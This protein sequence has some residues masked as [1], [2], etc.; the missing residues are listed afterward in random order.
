MRITID[1]KAL[2]TGCEACA[3]VCGHSAISMQEDRE[4]FCYPIIDDLKCVDCGL[5]HRICPI[6]NKVEK[7]HEKQKAFGGWINDEKILN[8][9]TSGGAFSAIADCWCN[10]DSY[11]IFGAEAQGMSVYHTYI[12]NKNELSRFRQS[13]YKQSRINDC[14]KMALTFLRE[15]KKVLFAGTPCQI[16]ALKSFVKN[17]YKNKLLTI[18]VIC[19]GVPSPML[20][21]KLE[22]KFGPISQLDY[23]YK[24]NNKWDFQ[25]M[26]FQHRNA[27]GNIKSVK[28][29][30]WFNPFWS[31]WLQHLISRPSCYKCPYTTQNRVADIT[32]GDL[33]GVHIYCPDLYNN[34]K[35]TS[36]VITNTPL[37]ER[38]MSRLLST[39]FCGRELDLNKA[40]SFQG[41]LRRPIKMNSKREE[42]IR[43]LASSM[44]YNTFCKKWAKSPSLRLLISKYF[45][46]T[47]RQ[48][49]NYWRLKQLIHKKCITQI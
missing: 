40:I 1:D 13:K 14:Y 33:W 23:R 9:S 46:G 30:R 49:V 48:K 16:A 44:D 39:T 6:I 18:E 17:K 21:R 36:L 42:C 22:Q 38:V 35:G 12:T 11:V 15:D 3:N 19:E 7:N 5:C 10:D 47:N 28:I 25:V 45:F 41:P 32:L 20:V 24:N 8:E 31:I 4:G 2:C 43:D 37:G 26:H 34:N 27:K 29:D